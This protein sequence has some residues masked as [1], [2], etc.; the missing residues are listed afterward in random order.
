M[1]SP[2]ENKINKKWDID[3][4]NAFCAVVSDCH[5]VLGC[6][7]TIEKKEDRDSRG[8]RPLTLSGLT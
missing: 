1:K 4:R 6:G 7:V 8:P 3:V 2:S 5:Q